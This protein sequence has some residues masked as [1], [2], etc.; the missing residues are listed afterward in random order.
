MEFALR[1]YHEQTK[2]SASSL[3]QSAHRLDWS[4]K[5][6]PYKIYSSLESIPLPDDLA[7]LCRYSNGVLR[8]RLGPSGERY[9]FR[10]APC[11][12]ALYHVEI[13]LATAE[14][15]DLPAGLYHYGAHDHRLRPLRRGDVRGALVHASGGFP[16]LAAAPLRVVVTSTVWR[17][18]WKYRERAYRHVY[19][20]GGVALANPPA[21]AAAAHEPA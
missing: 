21:P 18:A 9:G 20:D 3:A 7:R 10:A 4:N 13:Y 16:A 5:P 12:G 8:W 19:W 6:L 15:S 2:Y 17:N 11:T 14:R 1:D